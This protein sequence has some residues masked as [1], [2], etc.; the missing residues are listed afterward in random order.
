MSYDLL[1]NIVN[2]DCFDVMKQL[3]DKCMDVTFTSPPYN[4]VRNDTYEYFD[5]INDNYFDMLIELTNES[6][7]LSKKEVIINIQ[8]NMCNKSDFFRWLGC[9]HTNIK[10]IV[11][12]VK[13][14]PQPGTN[15]RESDDTYSITNAFEYFVVLGQDNKEFRAN[16]KFQN[17][18]YSNVNS[19]HFHGHGAVMRLDV[20]EK[21]IINFTK[22]NDLVFD[23]FMGMG[24]TAIACSKNNRNYFG[25][26]ISEV[27]YKRCLER[28][29]NQQKQLTLF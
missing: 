2:A 27:Y 9:F 8:Q 24:T 16:N 15:Y 20:A 3:E 23:P 7:R 13:N 10:G 4:R 14:N 28:V 25:C 1:N 22:P 12:W 29:C 21:M 5:D 6:L 18:I 19:E 17:V 26:E 11:A